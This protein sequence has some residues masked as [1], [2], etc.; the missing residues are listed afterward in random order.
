MNMNPVSALTR[1]SATPI[2]TRPD[3]RALV[4]AM[5]NEFD[6]IGQKLGLALPMSAHERIE[7]TG[8]L[9]DFRTSMLADAEAR[10]RL[11]HEGILGCVI[12]LA[13]KL[14]IAAPVSKT[15]YALLA[16]LDHSFART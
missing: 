10:R 6:A 16:G 9:G 12:E 11:E 3:L 5:M 2:L 8:K 13:Q 7:I 1:L 14:G 4:L 15:V